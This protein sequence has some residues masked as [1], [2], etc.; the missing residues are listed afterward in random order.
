MLRR[1][2]V[3]NFCTSLPSLPL[4]GNSLTRLVWPEDS[5]RRSAE[6]WHASAFCMPS[7]LFSCVWSSSANTSWKLAVTW[8]SKTCGFRTDRP[9]FYYCY[10]DKYSVNQE[11]RKDLLIHLFYVK[12]FHQKLSMLFSPRKLLFDEMK[13]LKEKVSFGLR[14]L[15]SGEKNGS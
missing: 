2:K 15:I 4:D 5:V 6:L 3:S 1:G 10:H 14:I 12:M 8:E 13:M 7:D 9:K 11:V